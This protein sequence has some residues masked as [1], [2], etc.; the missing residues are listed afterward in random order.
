[1][2]L[3]PKQWSFM[4]KYKYIFII[5]VYR[6]DND[7]TDCLESIRQKVSSY[8]VVVV[9][10]YYDDE[11]MF[12]VKFVADKYNCDFLN[13]ENHGYS[14]GNNRGIEYAIQKYNYD[15][16]VVSNPDIIVKQF[17]A[18]LLSSGPDIIA[19]N[20]VAANGRPQNPMYV[21]KPRLSEQIEYYGFKYKINAFVYMSVFISKW[22]RKFWTTLYRGKSTYR[23]YGAHGSFVIISKKAIEKIF[24]IYDENMFLFAEEMV[25]A[26]K[27]QKAG[28][29]T[30]YNNDIKI[31]HKEDG[32]MKLSSLKMYDV[33][34]ASNLYYYEHYVLNC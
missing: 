34:R 30:C 23:I 25:L 5:L 21:R 18:A 17:D 9:N 7:L 2:T 33:L 13:I 14:Y 1:M 32:S 11:S 22:N 3:T 8:K 27:A 4:N 26:A 29:L 12:A 6:N 31:Y 15:F 20:I 10:S 19:P 16:I 28:L 24:P